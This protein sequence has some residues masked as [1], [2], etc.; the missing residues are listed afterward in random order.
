[1]TKGRRKEKRHIEIPSQ[2]NLSKLTDFSILSTLSLV[3]DF[4][5][6]TVLTAKTVRDG[7]NPVVNISEAL[8]LWSSQSMVVVTSPT[9]EKTP[10][11]LAAI[12]IVAVEKRRFFPRKNRLAI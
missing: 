4:P 2:S 8:N 11:A 1:M 10:P 5:I 3:I 12:I 6:H 9:G 7:K